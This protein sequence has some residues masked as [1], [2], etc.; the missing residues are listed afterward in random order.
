[1]D[2]QSFF[3]ALAEFAFLRR[4]MLA[5]LL[6]GVVCST[7]SCFVVL[8]RMAF[9]GQGISHSAFAGAAVALLIVPAAEVN[10][11]LGSL[12]TAAFCVLVAVLIGLVSR[13]G[14]I[15][16]D[17]AIGILFAASMALAIVL[18]SA[19]RI[20]TVDI[21]SLLFG[22]ILSVSR[23][24]LLVMA[25]V[26]VAVLLSV[27]LL[28]KELLFYTFDEE[29]AQV[30][31]L[32]TAGLHYLLL[33]LLALTIVGAMKV[34]GVVLVSAFLVIPGA[35]ARDL[36]DKMSVMIIWSVVVGLLS[37][38]L[39]LYLSYR[40]ELPSGAL[41]VLLQVAVF[42]A[43]KLIVALLTHRRRLAAGVE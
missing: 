29:M 36:T 1:M 32:P 33:T 10:G 39:G 35:V 38:M 19:R 27:A 43:V 14:G 24:D 7:L 30:A 18:V 23:G 22:S 41:I 20:Y 6:V 34:V 4:A 11:P 17:S 42:F 12:I 15:S 9:I 13:R 3:S 31:G 40:L 2:E 28:F 25:V 16:E 26:G 8:R 37:T 5:G 21:M